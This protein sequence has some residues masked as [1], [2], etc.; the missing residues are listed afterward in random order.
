MTT[1]TP[2]IHV[3]V[4]CAWVCGQMKAEMNNHTPRIT[5]MMRGGAPRTAGPRSTGTAMGTPLRQG[6]AALLD[7]PHDLANPV[8]SPALER[9]SFRRYD[10]R[11]HARSSI[12]AVRRD[13]NPVTRHV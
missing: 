1:S 6:S 7:S 2:Q 8:P 10:D 3:F 9:R 5:L 13:S 12:A 4:I 11:P